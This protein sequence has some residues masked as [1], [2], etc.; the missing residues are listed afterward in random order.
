VLRAIVM[1]INRDAQA[2]CI[3]TSTTIQNG[4]FLSDRARQ[5][6]CE[7]VAH[8]VNRRIWPAPSLL[9]NREK[10]SSVRDASTCCVCHHSST[11]EWAAA[12]QPPGY[13]SCG[14]AA[15]QILTQTD[16]SPMVQYIA[17]I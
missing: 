9:H 14:Y 12:D 16:S 3:I 13:P 5:R 2:A 8:A 15:V 7:I 4:T 11:S 1:H 10:V 6:T 17:G